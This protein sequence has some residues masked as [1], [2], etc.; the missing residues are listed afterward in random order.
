M[1]MMDKQKLEI[2]KNKL[3]NRTWRINSGKLYKIKNKNS[4]VV[5]FKPNIHQRELHNSQHY[6]NVIVKARQLWFSTDIEIQALDYA[7]FNHNVNVGI[8]AHKK[9]LA[10]DI[11]QDKIK[12]ARDHLP[13]YIKNMYEVDSNSARQIVFKHKGTKAKSTIKVDTS[14][15]SGTVNFL[16]ISEFG[17][18]CAKYPKR[19]TEIVSGAIEAVPEN[20][21]L[22]IESTA[23]GG[24]GYFYEITKEAHDNLELNKKLNK[25]DYKFHFFPWRDQAEYRIE[26]DEKLS[27]EWDKYFKDLEDNHDI[28]L[29][30]AQ[31]RRYI[32]KSRKLWDRIYK[33]YPSYWE[34]AFKAAIEGAYYEKNLS[35]A[36]K[37]GRVGKVNV[38]KNYPVYISW[39]IGGAGGWDDA[40]LRFFQVIGKEYRFVK[41]WS[42]T[43]YS[44]EDICIEVIDQ[45]PYDI[46]KIF[47]PHDWRHTEQTIG[48]K[49]SDFVRQLWYNVYTLNI[50]KLSDEINLVRAN[51]E[52]CYIDK[53]ECEA[54]IDALWAYRRRYDEKNEVFRQKPL[55]NWA[56]HWAD[57]FRYAIRWI[58]VIEASKKSKNRKS[59]YQS[60]YSS[61]LY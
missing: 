25:F 50:W 17:K 31:K 60:D 14:F 47:L 23:E 35:Y 58:K 55:H 46:E 5:P 18:I 56:S 2:I 43:N 44:M 57:A 6:R 21:F 34:E 42:G 13:T 16:H 12:L 3:G 33:E 61:F 22:F 4:Q 52:D 15:R 29:D 19:A 30:T 38:K 8:I 7:L 28:T 59:V 26:A 37:Q 20:G 48:K 51:F 32:Q 10:E 27:D 1:M 24:T 49:R 36:R 54:W 45:T 9:D 40:A 39:D 11:F 53:D 41:Y